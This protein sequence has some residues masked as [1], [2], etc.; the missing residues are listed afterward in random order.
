MSSSESNRSVPAP[1]LEFLGCSTPSAWLAQVPN[2]ID[3]LLID[4]AHCEKKAAVAAMALIHRNPQERRLVKRMSRLAREELRHF[5]QVL[6]FLEARGTEFRE[7]GSPRY[8]SSLH[9]VCRPEPRDKLVDQLIIGAFIE[10]RSC[11]RFAAM[12]PV[13]EAHAEP[14]LAQFYRGLLAAEARH[15]VHYLEHAQD[16]TGEGSL[17]ERIAAIRQIETDLI[18]MPESEFRFHSGPPG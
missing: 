10:A 18:Q 7:I 4:H 17:A 3:L 6:R 8:A 1:L 5:E 15:F 13:L 16:L 12:A 14:D 9:A 11:E 2:N